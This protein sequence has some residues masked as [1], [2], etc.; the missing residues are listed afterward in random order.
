NKIIS[1]FSFSYR[2]FT[3]RQSTGKGFWIKGCHEIE[4]GALNSTTK[5][6][7]MHLAVERLVPLGGVLD[8]AVDG[9]R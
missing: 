4:Q 3:G 8:V 7:V 9:S 6:Q 1:L 2:Q 5:S